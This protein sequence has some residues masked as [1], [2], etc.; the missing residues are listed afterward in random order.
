M[1]SG[2]TNNY[3]LGLD[4]GIASVG[5]GM[6]NLNDS[7][8]VD[9]GVRLFEEADAANNLKRRTARSGRRLKRRRKNR[10]ADLKTLLKDNGFLK[11]GF[12]YLDNPYLIRVKGLSEKL[13]N[14][15]LC[16]ALLHLCKRRGSS[17]ETVE[18]DEAK[19]KDEEKAKGVLAQNDSQIAK[20]KYVCEI[21][22]ENFS[23]N[24]KIRG[25]GNIFRSKQYLDEA[26]KLL[27][28]QGIAED[29]KKEILAVIGRRRDFSEGPGSEKSPTI[30]GRYFYE[31]GELKFVN[32]IEKMRG[33]CSVYPDELRAPK[34]SWS[35]DL[36]NYLNDLNNLSF[37]DNQKLDQE[38]K[39][40]FIK[41]MDEKANLKPKDIAK[42]LDLSLD[43]IS[44]FR[45]DKKDNP[46]LTEF[47][48]YKTL[49]KIFEENNQAELLKDKDLL[50][51]IATVLTSSK[52]VE[53]R[54]KDIR[55]ISDSLNDATIEALAKA[56]GFSGYHSLSFKAIHEINKEMLVDNV[57]QMQVLQQNQAKRDAAIY[58]K[59]KKKIDFDDTAI[60]S[61]VAKQAIRQAIKVVNQLR[62]VH[63]EFN[64]IVI[65][66]ARE[67]N[68]AE[69]K[70]TIKESQK[71]FE[72]RRLKAKELY[73]SIYQGDPS[74]KLVEKIALYKEQDGKCLYTHKA[75]DLEQLIKDP[76]AYEVDHIIPISI[77]LDDSI[78][79]KVLVLPRANQAKK[80]LTPLMAIR[81]G[82]LN[83]ITE[84][85]YV[86]FIKN[87]AAFRNPRSK[88]RSYLLFED[89]INR[90][91]V[92]MKFINR[93]LVDTQYANRVVLNSM[94]AYFKA[95][96]IPTVVHTVKGAAT[97]AFRKRVSSSLDKDR[98]HYIHH[99][100]DA[101]IIASLKKQPIILE[102]LYQSNLARDEMMVQETG[103]IVDIKSDSVFF[104]DKY[105]RLVKSIAELDHAK[106]S[107]RVDRKPNR[108]VADETIYSTRNFDGEDYVIKKHKDIY[109]PGFL[110]LTQDIL[111]NSTDDYLM[112]MH[113]PKTFAKLEE[114]VQ[115]YLK[116]G[117]LQTTVDKKKNLIIPSMNPLSDYKEKHGP[118][119][120]YAKDNKGAPVTTLKYKEDKL[121]NHID[122]S[123]NYNVTDKKVVLLQISPFRTDIYQDAAGNYKF[124]TIRY[125]LPR[126]SAK[127]N[128]FEIDKEKYEEL[129][130]LP[131][132]SFDGTEKFLFSLYR[133]DYLSISPDEEEGKVWRFIGTGNDTTNKVEAKSLNEKDAK[134]KFFTIGKKVTRII[135]Y[136]F[137]VLGNMHQ[138]ESEDLKLSW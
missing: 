110:T 83:E 104:D 60:L 137:D 48:G 16:T 116:D 25:H 24:G 76:K 12:K 64:T 121:G 69:Q 100:V 62:K 67:K 84:T 101:L 109:N 42:Y 88:K 8:I 56:P 81:R 40:Y 103:E 15:E 136:N 111:N 41:V 127:K 52:V 5:W 133:N 47:K 70:A 108:Q 51:E 128:C 93:N 34:N 138:V 10:I 28:V 32:M 45:I 57:N 124:V 26:D 53:G 58:A 54:K 19:A 94:Q 91:D 27:S 20:G 79:N 95:N 120:K 11:D 113:D 31:D 71:F 37:N 89:D 22:L 35:A 131:G 97:S 17:L 106:F 43:D 3:V 21:Q 115:V 125:T 92:M 122:I 102:R 68:S 44:G 96:D 132:K 33:K 105:I 36:F 75:I 78:N 55:K 7:T 130:R 65:E 46:I 30:Y 135:K 114:I 86:T 123:K 63:G 61:P 107:W 118:V 85:E 126:Y 6:I 117:I 90:Y 1:D 112:K 99:A 74:G 98:D 2:K 29:L 14:D 50:D 87:Q 9:A 66:M 59:G 23:K 73:N 134:R 49:K 80:N 82:L 72:D 18:E 77:S 13:T 119:T 129:K 4:I 39:E 38:Q